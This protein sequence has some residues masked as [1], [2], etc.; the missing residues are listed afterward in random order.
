MVD[1]VLQVAEVVLVLVVVAVVLVVAGNRADFLKEVVA[2]EEME[3]AEE[4]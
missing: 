2:T 4:V 3:V 1:L